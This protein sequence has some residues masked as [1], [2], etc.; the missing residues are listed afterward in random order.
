[1]VNRAPEC[2]SCGKE[3]NGNDVVYVKL[4]YP[5]MKGFAE[6]KSYL[7]NEGEIMCEACHESK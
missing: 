7:R 1:M 3:I 2:A 4:R 6:V 5:I